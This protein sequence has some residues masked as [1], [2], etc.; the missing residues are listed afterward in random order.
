MV[1][2]RKIHRFFFTVTVNFIFEVKTWQITFG[3]CPLIFNE[4]CNSKYIKFQLSHT[5][6]GEI[7]RQFLDNFHPKLPK[8]F[9]QGVDVKIVIHGYGGLRVDTGTT[10]VT[11]AYEQ[12]KYDIIAGK[13]IS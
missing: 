10:N 5:R 3:D 2:I 7:H 4:P 6:N 8:G 12:K 11:E 1:E 13:L 9:G